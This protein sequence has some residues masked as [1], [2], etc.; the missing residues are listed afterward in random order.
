MGDRAVAIRG[1]AISSIATTGDR[2]TVNATMQTN[3][4]RVSLPP[5]ASVSISDELREIRGILEQLAGEN[6]GKIGRAVD[7][8]L[9][10][11]AK[12]KPDTDEI[13][14][15]LNRALGYAKGATGF[16]EEIEK[17]TPH[18]INAVAW[19]G[20]NWHTLLAAVGVVA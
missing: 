12:P 10:E 13:G 8:A 4:S 14:N 15:A 9:E 16:A 3:V 5:A 19:L 6:R 17:L 7:D 2:N 11:A 20:S 1:D 18:V